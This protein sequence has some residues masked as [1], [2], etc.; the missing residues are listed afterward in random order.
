MNSLPVDRS[1]P[2]CQAVGGYSWTMFG[3]F[4]HP[5]CCFRS[6]PIAVRRTA[7]FIRAKSW[8]RLPNR[9]LWK[10]RLRFQVPDS[11]TTLFVVHVGKSGGTFL[12]EILRISA[13]L[14]QEFSNVQVVHTM[15]APLHKKSKYLIVVRDPINRSLSA[16]NWRYS[17]VV[18]RGEP[19]RFPREA[20]VLSRYKSLS[21]LAED[22]YLKGVLNRSVERDFRAIHHLREDIQYHLQPIYGRISRDQL[23]AVITQENLMKD[24]W[25]ALGVDVQSMPRRN[26][27]SPNL[28]EQRTMSSKS[29]ENLSTFLRGEYQVLA[30][31]KGLSAGR[32]FA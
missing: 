9:V 19:G 28:P 20:Q 6:L 5:L 13:K 7:I 14:N 24:V 11:A 18:G 10:W 21:K 15:R 23:Y 17:L 27:S 22:L 4:V 16:F 8:L 1:D 25:E 2:S 3:K 31:L 12:R 30:W 29:R 26:T 32:D